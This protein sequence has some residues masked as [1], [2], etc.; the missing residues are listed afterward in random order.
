MVRVALVQMEVGS[1]KAQN[2]QKMEVLVERAVS[3]GAE[4]VLLP[5]IWNS[6][7]DTSA[8]AEYA[9]VVPKDKIHLH[10]IRDQCMSSGLM[11]RLADAHNIWLVGGSIPEKCEETG[12]V[13]N[14]LTVWNEEGD[15]VCKHRKVHLFDIDVKGDE[16]RGIKPMRFRESDSLSAGDAMTVAVSPFDG[17]KVG[18]GICYDL[19]FPEFALAQTREDAT[20]KALVF[21]GAFNRTTGPAHWQLL[22]RARALDTQCYV[23][24]C[25]PALNTES[26]YHS[27]GHSTVV[28]PWGDV[29]LELGD[30][31]EIGIVDI[32][33]SR[34][35]VVRQQIPVLQQ[36]RT[37]L[38]QCGRTE[39]RAE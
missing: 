10:E 16:A 33:L 32:D 38:Y 5:E 35:D 24:A 22:L 25:A 1:S 13:Y 34:V 29:I 39:T 14:T 31:E 11:S 28:S 30:D 37:D 23:M 18:F 6:P 7:Y 36:R 12:N 27:W 20:V 17:A 26:S 9:E 4:M 2:F 15:L 8:F 19:R 21:P 3:Q